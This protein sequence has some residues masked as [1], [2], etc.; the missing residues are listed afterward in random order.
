[1]FKEL[2]IQDSEVK[3]LFFVFLQALNRT[4]SSAKVS[5]GR[6]YEPVQNNFQ[7]DFTWMTDEAD[8]SVVLAVL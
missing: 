6:G 1:M 3:D 4:C 8:G 7:H 5:S 2:F